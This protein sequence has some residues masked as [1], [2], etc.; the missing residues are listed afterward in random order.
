LLWD[1]DTGQ[2]RFCG[3]G[4][5]LNG[6]AKVTNKGSVLALEDQNSGRTYR[7]TATCDAST[8]RGTA[9]LQRPPGGA[10]CIIADRNIRDDTGI[11]P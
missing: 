5:Q 4:T 1:S 9:S 2:Y 6:V 7:V 8:S 11:C 10:S 3:C